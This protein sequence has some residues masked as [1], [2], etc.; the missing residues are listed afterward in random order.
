MLKSNKFEQK[1][2][3]SKDQIQKLSKLRIIQKNLVHFQGFP[4]TL[5]DQ[6]LLM[7]K[8]HFGKF[9]KIL[10]IV[11]VSK[12]EESQKKKTNSA[13][14]TF[15]KIEE[16][17][18]AILSMDSLMI[19]GC[20]VRAFFGTTKYCIHFLNNNECKNKE[21]CM[22][23]HYLVNDN[24]ILG[25]NSKFDYNDHLNLAKQILTFSFNQNNRNFIID[26]NN[27]FK[28]YI[29]NIIKINFKDDLFDDNNISEPLIRKNST[30]SSNSTN[31]SD[32]N[33]NHMKNK[34]N[35]NYLFK[36]K[37]ESRFFCNNNVE[38]NN[39][40]IY[41]SEPL[42][43]LI[44]C[45]CNRIGFF[46]ENNINEFEIKLYKKKYEFINDPFINQVFENTF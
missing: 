28:N 20:L 32:I 25:M 22:F 8:S 26:F 39:C 15:S 34:Q 42:K 17:A 3:F 36:Y 44:D 27:S 40:N 12:N 33:V 10:K 43:K 1:F 21:K 29:P 5:N 14:I 7:Q 35:E 23:I 46:N 11:L 6:N 2:H 31:N 30:S 38:N 4:D 24:D 13:Y 18:N 16:A 41:I 45:L 19:E 9:G 37:D